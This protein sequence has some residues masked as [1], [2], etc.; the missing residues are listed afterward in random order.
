MYYLPNFLSL[1]WKLDKP[2]YH[3]FPP[4]EKVLK[5]VFGIILGRLGQFEKFSEIKPP[6]ALSAAILSN[7]SFNLK[8]MQIG[9]LSENVL[10]W[11]WTQSW[12]ILSPSNKIGASSLLFWSGYTLTSLSEKLTFF[13][14][15]NWCIW[16]K[17]T[18]NSKGQKILE[19]NFCLTSLLSK[20]ATEI[21]ALVSIKM[22]QN[23]IK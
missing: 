12:T 2:H 3:N 10:V 6:L 22:D 23:K 11:P 4:L 8:R 21:S 14:K 13:W 18:L 17:Y 9:H 7:F 20:I 19:S 16:F 5:I 1:S 15:M